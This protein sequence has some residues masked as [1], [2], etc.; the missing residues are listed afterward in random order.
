MNDRVLERRLADDRATVL[1]GQDIAAAL[2]S[3]DVVALKGDLGAGKTTL[4]RGLIRA[5]A[6]DPDLEVPSPTFTLVQ[7]YE[8]RLPIQ[9]FDLYRL[10]SVDELDEL[11][12]DEASRYGIAI[13][14]WPERAGKHLPDGTIVIELEHEGEGRRATITGAQA[15]LARIERSFAARDFLDQTGN[16]SAD[17]AFFSGDASARSYETVTVGGSPPRILM[18]SP[19]LVLGPPVRDGKPYAEIAHTA[20]T[21]VAFVAIARMLKN[22]GVSVPEIFAQ[23]LGRGFLL[24]ENLGTGNFLDDQERPVPQRLVAAAGLLA[25][26]HGKAWPREFE[27]A[28]GVVYRIP[29]FDRD[30]M[31]IEVELLL[32]W[33]VPAAFG[34]P[35]SDA[36]RSSFVAAW[37]KV[38]DR[39]GDKEQGFV[40]R[41]FQSP[42]IIWRGD[43]AGHDRL[44]IIDFQD[45]LIG[46][47]AYDVAS[48][49]L[50]AR[51]TMT[52]ELEKTTVEAYVAARRAQGGFDAEGFAEAYAIMA[53][54]RNSKILGIFVRLDRRDGKPG[55]LR[56]LPRIRGY[57]RRVLVHPSLVELRFFYE[58]SGFLEE[59]AL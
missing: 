33:Y 56:H 37:N 24:I 13:V 19:R 14:E 27:A 12:F 58:S 43:R 49:A 16:E 59:H 36:A 45:G 23:D 22:G 21:V 5:L 26:M 25:Q 28:P 2:R 50:D 41:D 34:K 48:I 57:L 15:V 7:G 6:A 1:M 38:F 47:T 44:G 9:H 31:L 42:N 30:A 3:G 32:N 8:T 55:Y 10:S 11:G 29:P 52:A 51:V 35:A 17:R 54:Q 39:L 20:Q 53:A 4:A 46:P 18:N 40:H